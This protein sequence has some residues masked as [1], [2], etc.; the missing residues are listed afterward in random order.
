[1]LTKHV[2]QVPVKMSSYITVLMK[3]DYAG[4]ILVDASKLAHNKKSY[5]LHMTC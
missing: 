3:N 5:L 2:V 1:M 4:K